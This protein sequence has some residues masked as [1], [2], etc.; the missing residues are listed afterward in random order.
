MYKSRY[1]QYVNLPTVPEEVLKDLP[2]DINV[3][4]KQTLQNYHWTDS[5][6]D[7]LN[8]WAQE[9]ICGEI[10]YA[11][12]M[13]TGDIPCH[14]DIDTKTKF[15]YILDTGGSNVLTRFWD[16]DFNLLDEYV[17]EP[18]RWH[19]LKADTYHSVEGIEADKFRWS[20]TARIF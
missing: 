9:N 18:F 3:Y 10:Y 5:F 20:I 16:D 2:T 6:N 12:Q 19:I 17:I 14:K 7:K 15:V 13:M 4:K 11:F 1:I 8:V